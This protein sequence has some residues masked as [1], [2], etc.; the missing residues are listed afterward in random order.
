MASLIIKLLLLFSLWCLFISPSC[1]ISNESSTLHNFPNEKKVYELFQ[2]WKMEFKREYQTIEE[3]AKRFEIFKR[4]LKYIS[5]KN[6]KTTSSYTLGLNKFSDL[7]YEEFRKIYLHE[8][9]NP[10]I[11]NNNRE[12]MLNGESC[13]DAPTSLDWRT[14]GAVTYVKDQKQCGKYNLSVFFAIPI[15]SYLIPLLIFNLVCT[16]VFLLNN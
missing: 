14:S 4:N 12:F 15:C 2:T 7:S 9:E 16:Y 11:N 13:P 8:T 3:E 5:D 10:I 6:A 1:C